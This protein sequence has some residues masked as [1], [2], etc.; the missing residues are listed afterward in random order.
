MLAVIF[1]TALAVADTGAFFAA[2]LAAGLTTFAGAATFLGAAFGDT[3]FA[4]AICHFLFGY[5]LAQIFAS[6]ALSAKL[7]AMSTRIVFSC[8]YR[9]FWN[10]CCGDKLTATVPPECTQGNCD[11]HHPQRL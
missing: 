3:F 8:F 10:G 2:A 6:A 9:P 4:V 5:S 11:A 1:V 7:Q